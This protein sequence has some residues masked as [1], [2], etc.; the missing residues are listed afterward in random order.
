MFHTLRIYTDMPFGVILVNNHL[1][2]QFFFSYMFITILYMSR[3]G[4]SCLTCILDGHLHTVTYTRCC[5]DTINSP[6]DEH[7][8]P[9][10][11]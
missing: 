2:A 1:D 10:S 6:D 5:I 4:S 8:V 3:A 9:R 11:R 7:G